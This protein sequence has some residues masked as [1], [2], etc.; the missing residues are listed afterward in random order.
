[1]FSRRLRSLPPAGSTE[2]SLPCPART[3]EQQRCTAFL[4]V[5]V[6]GG[7]PRPAGAHCRAAALYRN[8]FR[9]LSSQEVNYWARSPAFTLEVVTLPEGADSQR[10]SSHLTFS[11]GKVNSVCMFG[12]LVRT[13]WRDKKAQGEAHC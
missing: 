2:P 8:L 4:S 12:G 11:S 7:R 3:V 5:T 13:D 10:E 9:P 6:F 1:M